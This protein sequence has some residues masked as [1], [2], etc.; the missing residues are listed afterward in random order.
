[1]KLERQIDTLQAQS[2]SKWFE[3][4]KEGRPED[5]EAFSAW[6]RK[7]P[8]HI[9]EFLEITY[10]DRVLD[11]LDPECKQDLD[12]ILREASARVRTFPKQI[13]G[14][15]HATKSLKRRTWAWGL[16][17]A[18]GT[19]TVGLILYATQAL[20]TQEF[21]TKIGEQR[22]V[23]LVD[24]S[25]INM[26]TD[27]E[28]QV[29]FARDVRDIELLRGEVVFRVAHDPAR[30][31]RVHTRAG[32]VQAI[33]TQFNVYDRP[34]GTDVAVLEGRVRLIP[35]SGSSGT[36][37]PVELRAG[38]EARIQLD[39]SIRRAVQADVERVTAWSK[40]RLKFDNTPLEEMVREF[41][42][43]HED[44]RLRLD[45]VPV[46][47]HHYSGIFDAD[48]LVAL[49]RLLEQEPDLLLER[50]NGEMV[51]RPRVKTEIGE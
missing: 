29:Q 36:S 48:D 51:I 5:T 46:R 13:G 7:S 9:Q 2:A 6:C 1:M 10:T 12:K 25:V 4:L 41:N 8:L 17:A 39:G 18:L 32:I 38:E 27:S 21:T 22:T 19:C 26:N 45:G 14:E 43:Y 42:R 35:G 24:S 49:A 23:A 11:Q 16:A 15:A 31:F 40:R 37:T 28:I 50:G 20:S 34:E 3:L 30:P 47:S 44:L 33:G